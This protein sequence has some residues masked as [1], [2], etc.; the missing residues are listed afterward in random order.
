MKVGRRWVPEWAD[1]VASSCTMKARPL[2]LSN[3]T[4]RSASGAGKTMVALWIQHSD[5]VAD[6]K[7]V[8]SRLSH[9]LPDTAADHRRV[10]WYM[11][12][13]LEGR[14]EVASTK[15]SKKRSK[16]SACMV[17]DGYQFGIGG[18]VLV[19]NQWRSQRPGGGRPWLVMIMPR[20]VNMYI[21]VNVDVD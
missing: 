16:K 10:W 21:S 12:G 8:L 18:G 5:K 4:S 2:N 19:R 6:I 9:H 1:A 13:G 3:I 11:Y 17:M 20:M 7:L 14:R 15:R